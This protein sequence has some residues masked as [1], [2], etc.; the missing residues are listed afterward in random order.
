MSIG[1]LWAQTNLR[2][3]LHL[4]ANSND[5]SGNALNGTD[6][7]ITYINGVIGGNGASFN[8]STSKIALSSS[9]DTPLKTAS[10]TVLFTI[11]TGSTLAFYGINRGIVLNSY[12]NYYGIGLVGG[13]TS[14]VATRNEGTATSRTHTFTTTISASTKYLVVWTYNKS[15]GASVLYLGNIATGTLLSS[16]GTLGTGIVAFDASYDVGYHLNANLRNVGDGYGNGIV[17]ETIVFSD[18]KTAA[19]IAKYLSLLRGMY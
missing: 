9:L 18:I 8:G 5:Y 17:N 10:F 3:G 11:K 16:S 15:S 2:M 12:S 6:A 19:W 13:A 4:N 14:L 7:N 1:Q